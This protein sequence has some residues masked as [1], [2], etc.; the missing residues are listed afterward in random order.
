MAITITG[1]QDN[2]QKTDSMLFREAAITSA[3]QPL[4]R[5]QA[6]LTPDI[7]QQPLENLDTLIIINDDLREG[8]RAFK[9]SNIMNYQDA[10]QRELE[11]FFSSIESDL[12]NHAK[13][14]LIEVINKTVL[15]RKEIEDAKTLPYSARDT[16]T[17]KMVKFLGKEYNTEIKACCLSRLSQIDRLL[18]GKAKKHRNLLVLI[19]SLNSE[20]GKVIQSSDYHEELKQKVIDA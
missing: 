16:D 5:A 7:R 8:R 14:L 1:C 17:S 9:Q 3:Q 19:R 20:L 4:L 13:D 15:L 10:N 2:Q 11:D 12:V 6:R 18:A